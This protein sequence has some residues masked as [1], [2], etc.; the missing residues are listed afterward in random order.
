[1][2]YFF[3]CSGESFLLHLL[4]SSG[5]MPLTLINPMGIMGARVNVVRL[6]TA[7]NAFLKLRNE[8]KIDV[9]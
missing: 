5:T 9:H 8:I 3:L 7:V 2:K 4:L 1:M 6:T